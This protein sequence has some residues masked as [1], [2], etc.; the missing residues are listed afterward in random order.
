MKIGRIIGV[1]LVV[2]LLTGC[3]SLQ[4]GLLGK[5]EVDTT[6]GQKNGLMMKFEDGKP[7]ESASQSEEVFVNLVVQNVGKHEVENF[8]TKFVGVLKGGG[9]EVGESDESVS[10]ES[11]NE[12]GE[13][14]EVRVEV[15]SFTYNREMITN[16]REPL[17]E[18]EMCY[19]Y[20]TDVFSDFYVGKDDSWVSK[21][22]VSSS[23]N[24]NGPVHITGF[25]EVLSGDKVSFSFVVK[26]VGN[27]EIVGDCEGEDE[28]ESDLVEVV[29]S[30]P[31]GVRCNFPDESNSG[32]VRLIKGSKRVE[33]VLDISQETNYKDVFEAKLLYGYKDRL[34][35]KIIIKK[36]TSL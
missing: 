9:F 30:S 24:S 5:K 2:L 17:I 36:K 21:G 33:C 18:V 10:L 32:E 19:D 1:L 15:G 28:F 23:D 3:A 7:P 16:L 8:D 27:G 31:E 34:A 35:D 6:R 29:V 25:E 22:S 13:S 20:G 11:L 14:E 4:G 12:F 26:H